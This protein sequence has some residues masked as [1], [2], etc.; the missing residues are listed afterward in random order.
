MVLKT[1]IC[2]LSAT[3]MKPLHT[4][5]IFYPH[6]DYALVAQRIEHRP[7]TPGCRRFDSYQARQKSTPLGRA[8]SFYNSND[9]F[10][11]FSVFGVFSRFER[12]YFSQS[13]KSSL[14]FSFDILK[15]I[16]PLVS[17]IRICLTLKNTG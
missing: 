3:L 1:A 5:R 17:D 7:P 12:R 13:E 2:C 16:K 10:R 4:V 11:Y 8:F 15:E 6:A 14:S 9:S